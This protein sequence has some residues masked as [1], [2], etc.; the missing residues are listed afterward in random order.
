MGI[1]VRARKLLLSRGVGMREPQ[2]VGLAWME[3]LPGPRLV[4][5]PGSRVVVDHTVTYRSWPD[6]PDAVSR[7]ERLAVDD[8]D[9]GLVYA[10]NGAVIGVVEVGAKGGV[11]LDFVWPDGLPPRDPA[12]AAGG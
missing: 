4:A 10:W 3:E 11:I 7:K 2:P 5:P 1:G 8:D 12:L 9:F 6:F